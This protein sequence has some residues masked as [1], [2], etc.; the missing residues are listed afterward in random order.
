VDLRLQEGGDIWVTDVRTL[1]IL[2]AQ[3]AFVRAGAQ[4]GYSFPDLM[5]R[6]VEATRKRARARQRNRMAANRPA[7]SLVPSS[8]PAGSSP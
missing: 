7:P 6:I 2:A 3:G 5:E 8:D 4:G 1:G